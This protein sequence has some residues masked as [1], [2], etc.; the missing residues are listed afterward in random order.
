M[1]HFLYSLCCVCALLLGSVTVYADEDCDQ[2]LREARQAYNAGQYQRAKDLCNYVI[3]VCGATYGGVNNL[4]SEIDDALTPRLTVS[5]SNISVGPDAG[6]TTITVNCNRSWE[7]AN[8][9][10]TLFTVSR[11]GNTVTI[12][13]S[14]NRTGSQRSDYFDVQTTDRTKSARIRV[15][16]SAPTPVAASLSVSPS[17]IDAPASGTTR[18]L[19]V[20]CNTSWEVEYP[21][22]TMYSVTRN[23]NTLTV[24]INENTSSSPRSD[25]FNVKT[26]DGSSVQRINMSQEG[27]YGGGALSVSRTSINVGYYATT[28][29]I[30]VSGG[31]SWEVEYPTATMYSVTRNGNSLTVRINENT[32]ANSRTDFFN[33]KGSDGTTIRINLSQE[34]RPGGSYVNVSRTELN[35]GPS[36]TTEYLTVSANQSW[37]VEYPTATMYSVTRNGNSLT[38]HINE[39]TSTESRT[40]F[41][42]VKASDGSKVRINIT[43]GGRTTSYNSITVSRTELSVGP[44]ATTEYLTVSAS[45]S[46]EVEYP[47]A[48]MYSVT[49]NGNTLTVH[50]NENTSTE[51]RTDF[52][53]V[54]GYDGTKV[55]INLSQSGRTPS[56]NTRITVSRTEL[57]AGVSATNEYLTVTSNVSWE[58]EYPSGTMYSVTRNGNS[59]TVHFNEN[60]S[61]ESRTD[62]F[63][64]KAY[65]GTK[66][67]INLRQAGRNPSITVSRPD[68]SVGASA[69]TEYITVTARQSWE[70][71]Y[72]SGTMYSVT[73]SGNTLTVRINENTSTESR[74]DFFNVKGSDGTK[75]RV[76]MR[77]A[78]RG[79]QAPTAEID[80]IWVDHNVYEDGVKGMRIHIKMHVHNFRSKNGRA[81]VYFYDNNGNALV[82]RNNSYNT[83]DGK[84][85]VGKNFTPNYDNTVFDDFKIFMPYNELHISYQGTFKFNVTLWNKEVSP[86]TELVESDWKY[87]TYTP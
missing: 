59:L 17:S 1:K 38:V 83:T 41:F 7:L 54:K 16:Q 70:I 21:S 63:N 45:Q 42:N 43:Q 50:I 33:V 30:T 10:S 75:V 58:V 31:Q 86:N 5:R 71:E 36:A 15:T 78:G 81:T 56:G 6:T 26:T 65:D 51:S 80:D 64:V 61:N 60:T 2:S 18:Y 29:Y 27:G 55:R 44:S 35:V 9:N 77:Q 25:Y 57:S 19:T 79:T 53:N 34:G 48:T 49:R 22:G 24:Y 13:Y 23:G 4:M 14:E 66:V 76:N 40:D 8:T 37:E 28:E 69:T 32:S 85:A 72:P 73:R 67:R 3:S 68:L 74:T 84:V 39:N 62:F 11:S 20:S 47:T 12:S 82:D 87:F 46:W 52:F